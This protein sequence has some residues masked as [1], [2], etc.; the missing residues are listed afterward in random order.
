MKL[1]FHYRKPFTR[2][3]ALIEALK[4]GIGSDQVE[5][6]EDHEGFAG[7]RADADALVLLGIGG[8]ARSIWDAYLAAG[9]RVVLFDKGYSRGT[10]FLRVSCGAFQPHAYFRKV[11]R[12]LDRFDRLAIRLAPYRLTGTHILFD[13]ASNKFCQWKGFG[14]W[15]RWGAEMVALIKSHTSLPV[16]YRPRPSH[17]PPPAVP[18]AELS[19]GPLEQD[20]ARARVVVSWGGAM[21]FDAVCAGVPHFAIGDSI[22][23]TMSERAWSRLDVPFVP[24]DEARVRF[25]ADVAYCQW[26]LDEIASGQAWPFIRPYLEA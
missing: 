18:G 3:M 26:T 20:F 1:V 15:A 8:S 2:A 21:G 24:T 14:D 5:G 9:K 12:P 22:A 4:S 25:C 7:V 16:I 6:I 17:N 23:W 13:G 10:G 19:E 11:P